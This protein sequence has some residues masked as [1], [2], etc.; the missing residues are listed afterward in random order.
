M[1]DTVTGEKSEEVLPYLDI[2]VSFKNFV[3]LA[4]SNYNK[5]KQ[6]ESVPVEKLQHIWINGEG[7]QLTYITAV[8]EVRASS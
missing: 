2:P 1:N 8:G 6:I 3:K 5:R 4:I 7:D